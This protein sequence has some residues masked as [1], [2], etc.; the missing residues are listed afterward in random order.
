MYHRKFSFG[1]IALSVASFV[2][3][4]G[5]EFLPVSQWPL[6]APGAFGVVGTNLD[7]GRLVL[8][9]GGSVY[10]QDAPGGGRF[11][12]VATGYAGDPGFIALSPDGDTL[13]LGAGF[14][15]RMYLVD[16]NAPEDY[17]LSSEI[18]APAQYSGVYLNDSL[19]AI[20]RSTDDFSSTE[21]IVLDISGS[22]NSPPRGVVLRTPPGTAA[23]A[24]VLE[25]PE[26]SFSSNVAVND[27]RTDLYVMDANARELRRFN[28]AGVIAAFEGATELDWIADGALIGSVGDYFT[29]GV[30]GITP[31]GYLVIGGS[32]GFALPGGI[33]IVDPV[34]GDILEVLDPAGTQPFYS[35]IYNSAL[36]QII[37]TS[38][39]FIDPTETFAPEGAIAPLPAM[40]AI[41]LIVL[42]AIIAVMARR[43]FARV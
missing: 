13:L 3:S 12:A 6:P 37:A 28:V 5:E 15:P 43:R 41:G 35:V 32:A 42:A 24:T 21:I 29:G 30:S 2:S 39:N 19:I 14:S 34:T 9:N 4:H 1:A 31:E 38:N 33:Q 36:D 11:N 16:V 26:F 17:T 10:F 7:D 18:A 22:K 23:K 25:K 27:D 40:G 8:W 20:D